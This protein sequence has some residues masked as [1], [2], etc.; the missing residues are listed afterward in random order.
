MKSIVTVKASD[1]DNQQVSMTKFQ[2]Q[3]ILSGAQVHVRYGDELFPAVV[4]GWALDFPMVYSKEMRLE[5]EISWS[6]AER[7]ALQVR[8]GVPATVRYN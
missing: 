6:L 5:M 4:Q 3:Q 1:T 7:L 8:A 2:M